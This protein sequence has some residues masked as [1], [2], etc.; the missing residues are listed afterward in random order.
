MLR[1]N[2]GTELLATSNDVIDDRLRIHRK[3][4]PVSHI[5]VFQFVDGLDECSLS[6]SLPLGSLIWK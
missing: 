2:Q 1:I 5:V 3:T 4:T 6:F